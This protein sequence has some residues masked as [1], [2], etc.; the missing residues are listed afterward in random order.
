MMMLPWL[1]HLL[2]LMQISQSWINLF[3]LS[4]V[5]SFNCVSFDIRSLI[6]FIVFLLEEDLGTEQQ[7]QRIQGLHHLL[8]SWIQ[9]DGKSFWH[10]GRI[11][12]IAFYD[13]IEEFVNNLFC[14]T[15]KLMRISLKGYPF[16]CVSQF[17]HKI[18]DVNI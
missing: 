16:Y 3:V 18:W 2:L 4:V 14:D 17:D 6:T 1:N 9:Q 5:V 12:S 7:H 15:A 11:F 13:V 8:L 10:R